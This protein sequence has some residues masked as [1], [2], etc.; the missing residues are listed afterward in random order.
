MFK[1]FSS[2]HEMQMKAALSLAKKACVSVI[3]HA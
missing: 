3:L 2:Q 1:A